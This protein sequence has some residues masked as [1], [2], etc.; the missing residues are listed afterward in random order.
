MPKKTNLHFNTIT[1]CAI[2]SLY[3]NEFITT[4]KLLI[5]KLQTMERQGKE[6]GNMRYF[7]IVGLKKESACEC[8]YVDKNIIPAS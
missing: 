5:D 7:G 6:R 2:S 1:H 3:I 8:V 4:K